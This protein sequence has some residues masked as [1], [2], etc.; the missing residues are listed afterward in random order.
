MSEER[1]LSVRTDD[2]PFSSV[3]KANSRGHISAMPRS[4]QLDTAAGKTR[5][6]ACGRRKPNGRSWLIRAR[7]TERRYSRRR[8][9]GN[10]HRSRWRGRAGTLRPQPERESDRFARA[11]RPN[12]PSNNRR[13][14]APD[15]H[16]PRQV[17][18]TCG[19]SCRSDRSATRAPHKQTRHRLPARPAAGR[20]ST[21]SVPRALFASQRSFDVS[22][23]P[24]RTAWQR[25]SRVPHVTLVKPYPMAQTDI[26]LQLIG[27]PSRGS[28]PLARNGDCVRRRGE[29]DPPGRVIPHGDR[30]S[31]PDQRKRPYVL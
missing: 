10:A 2:D 8:S 5:Q 18:L 29:H 4:F 24:R 11:D 21:A 7:T 1:H 20:K 6:K 27:P 28:M 26:P 15:W 30:T 16:S 13:H 14:L 3:F 9:V 17:R 31:R 23:P 12:R 25:V 22:A 19:P